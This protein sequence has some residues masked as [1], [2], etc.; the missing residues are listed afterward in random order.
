MLIY[1]FYYKSITYKEFYDD[2]KEVIDI[3][4]PAIIV[5]GKNDSIT[6]NNSY[7]IN[8]SNH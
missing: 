3:Y 1:Q 7:K 2:F 5:Y 8:K 6:L 4:H